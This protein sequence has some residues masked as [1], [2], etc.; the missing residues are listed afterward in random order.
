MEGFTVALALLDYV[1]VAAFG[2]AVVIAGAAMNSPLF[3]FGA[4]LSFL[5]GLMKA[6]WKLILGGWKKD[7][8]F[9]N[10]AFLPMQGAGWLIMLPAAII[11]LLRAGPAK[12]FAVLGGM[13]QLVFFLLW[14]GMMSLMVWYKKN[15]FKKDNAKTNWTA[16]II[17]SIGQTCF[18]LAIIFAS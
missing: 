14:I 10:K 13:P 2:A 17:N 11:K 12:V 8:A 6:T 15:R 1:P 16:E 18:L 4:A 9:M 3:M 7:I 5:A